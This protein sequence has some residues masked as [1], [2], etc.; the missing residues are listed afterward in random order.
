MDAVGI[1]DDSKVKNENLLTFYLE[2][3]MENNPSRVDS[4][5][6]CFGQLCDHFNG[7][8]HKYLSNT[9]QYCLNHRF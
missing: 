4:L 2:Q 6:S 1:K 5:W 7:S 8:D 3:Q 9:A